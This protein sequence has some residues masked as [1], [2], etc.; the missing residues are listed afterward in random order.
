ME[1]SEQMNKAVTS[2]MQAAKIIAPVMQEFAKKMNELGVKINDLLWK[3][4][5]EAGHPYG[6]NYTGRDRWLR[7]RA[8]IQ[9]LREK[10]DELEFWHES[11]TELRR[12]V[13][14]ND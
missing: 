4:Y 2:M 5:E 11:M 7:E 3:A 13:K 6:P 12:I 1:N 10:A 9:Q 8:E 14:G